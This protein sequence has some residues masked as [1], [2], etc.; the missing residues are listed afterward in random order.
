MPQPNK[1]LSTEP[2]G[3]TADGQPITMI[4]LRNQ[5]GIEVRV[6]TY[7][8]IILS[9]K[10]PDK[11]GASGDIVLGHDTAAEYFTNSPFI[12][13]L[14]GRYGNRIAK[15]KFTL[16]GHEYTLA[17]NNGANH[18]HGG[19]KGWDQALWTA[20]PF[21]GKEGPG[22]GAD[23]HERGRRRRVSRHR[24]GEGHLHAHRR[25]S[26][27]RRVLGDDRQA[28]GDQPDAAQL[29]QSLGGQVARHPRP[30]ADDQRGAV[31]ARSTTA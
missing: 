28:D 14:I 25:Q 7:G 4:S 16:D 5:H 31:H 11:S 12:G 19:K 2:F 3:Q 23:A 1:Y 13:A 20:E 24:E 8:G 9:I 6:M 18:L 21:Q 10:T 30:R 27:A 29:L 26:P 17:T 22:R 15:G